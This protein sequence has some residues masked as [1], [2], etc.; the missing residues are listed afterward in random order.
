MDL[1]FAAMAVRSIGNVALKFESISNKCIAVFLDLIALKHPHIVQ[2]SVI[3]IKDIF[4]KYPAHYEQILGSLCESFDMLDTQESKAAM[5]WVFGE[6]AEK[7][8]GAKGP[9]P[10]QR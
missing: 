9:T 1:H 2:E 5:I 6:Y 8:G 7:N 3:V 4:R 10:N